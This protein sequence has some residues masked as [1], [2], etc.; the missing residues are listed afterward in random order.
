[1][2][3]LQCCVWCLEKTLRYLTAYAFVYVALQ[4][5][6]FCL[7]CY[8]TFALITSHAAQLALNSLVRA[9]TISNAGFVTVPRALCVALTC[10]HGHGHGHVKSYHVHVG[11]LYMCA[12]P[13]PPLRAHTHVCTQVRTILNLLQLLVIP[14]GCGWITLELA[15]RHRRP[16]PVYAAACAALLALLIARAFALVMSCALD[17]LFVCCVR[18]KAEYRGAFMSDRLHL[19]FGFDRSERRERRKATRAAKAASAGEAADATAGTDHEGTVA[20]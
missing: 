6:G 5:S 4:G 7:A 16:E 3:G 18:D 11:M 10:V 13:T 12:P 20:P 9:R 8:R 2:T 19:A 14:I 17:T 15:K 1:M